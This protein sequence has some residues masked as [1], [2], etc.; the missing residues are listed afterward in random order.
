MSLFPPPLSISIFLI[1]QRRGAESARVPLLLHQ[2]PS[3]LP[4]LPTSP[5]IA[6]P[7][8]LSFSPIPTRA[9]STPTR[10]RAPPSPSTR[11]TRPSSRISNRVAFKRRAG[12]CWTPLSLPSAIQ[13]AWRWDGHELGCTV[14]AR[15][16]VRACS[17]LCSP[18]SQYVQ[19]TLSAPM[20]AGGAHSRGT[21]IVR[22][23]RA[24]ITHYGVACC[25][26]E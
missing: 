24:A 2:F 23:Q 20:R 14:G 12:G 10:R 6:L 25:G 18:P 22:M 11:V 13:C 19:R 26:R 4:A 16:A 5:S 8:A 17:L 3:A 7:Y 9:G 1:R 21:P 15:T